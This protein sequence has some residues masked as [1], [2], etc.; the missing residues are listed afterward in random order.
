MSEQKKPQLSDHIRQRTQ[1]WLRKAEHELA[2]LAV[3]LLNLD[4]P[5]TDTTCRIAHLAAEYALEAY[6]MIN[7]HKI[8]KSHD[9]GYNS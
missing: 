6:L 5:P 9:L 3:A 4:D 8:V 7:K 2:Y 1:E